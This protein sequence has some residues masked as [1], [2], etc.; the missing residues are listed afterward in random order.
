MSLDYNTIIRGNIMRKSIHILSLMLL[1]TLLPGQQQFDI[2]VRNVSVPVRVFDGD[3]F[4]DNLTLDDFEVLE[5]GK[6]QKVMALYLTRKA[7][8]ERM[9]G[10][11]YMPYSGRSFYFIFQLYENHPRIIEALEYFFTNIYLPEDQLVV[12]TPLKV[13]EL[14]KDLVANNPKDTVVEYI[15]GTIRKDTLMAA[16]QYNSLMKD[17]IR[18][19]QGVAR[20]DVT[21]ALSQ[22]RQNLMKLE[23]VTAQDERRLVGF[24]SQLKRLDGQKNVFYFCQS[25]FRP[26]LRPMVLSSLLEQ[27]QDIPNTY[28]ELQELFTFYHKESNLDVDRITQIFA[29]SSILFNFIFINKRP[30]GGGG[31]IQM[32]E[33]SEDVFGAFSRIARSTGGVVENSQNLAAALEKSAALAESYYLLYYSPENYRKDG[34]YKNITIKIKGKKYTIFHRLG[35]MAD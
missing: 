35:Y 21:S 29:D 20:G 11:D 19:A 9:E 10:R 8:V 30:E 28:G 26:K 6:P 16:Q 24:A 14:N 32:Q 23:Q 13:Y 33:Q 22:Y 4:V 2:T 7:K 34:K 3:R 25:E 31:S 1:S 17:L 27:F 18:N 15:Q 5:D 12:M